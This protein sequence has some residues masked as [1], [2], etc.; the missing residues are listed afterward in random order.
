MNDKNAKRQEKIKGFEQKM[1][2]YVDKQIG[3][4][5]E[6]WNLKEILE[7]THSRTRLQ[8]RF[9]PDSKQRNIIC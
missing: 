5:W 6:T 2:V 4:N 3:C 1:N 9:T 7:L 8:N